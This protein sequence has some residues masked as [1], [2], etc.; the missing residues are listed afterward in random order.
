[1]KVGVVLPVYNQD[2]VY[3]K[4]AILSMESQTYRNFTF[5]IVIDGANQETIDA[6]Y[7]A[8]TQLTCDYSI[9]NRKENM[10][11]AHSLNEGFSHLTDCTHLTWVSSDNR[12][13]P[14]FLATLVAQYELAPINT[15]LVYSLYYAINEKGERYI[16]E[17]EWITI[18]SKQM[19]RKKEIIMSVCF[20]GVSF[21][22][23]RSAFEQAGGYKVEYGKVAD[24][25]L[26]MR[27][28]NF[29]EFLFLPVP[30]I[31]YRHN[32]AYSLTTQT[33]PEEL[34]QDSM[35]ASI[36]NRIMDGDIP[37]V[38]VLITAHNHEKYIKQCLDSV[39]NQT[40]KSFH[41]VVAVDASTD[42]TL[43]IVVNNFDDS[44]IIPI[45]LNKQSK[46]H[47][48]NLGLEYSLGEYILEL[49]GDDWIDPNTLETMVNQMENLPKDVGMA[50]ANR[51]LWFEQPDGL[52]YGG[53]IYPGI[54]YKDKYEVLSLMQTHCPRLY[55]KSALRQIGGWQTEIEGEPLHAD[56]YM[57]F[58]KMSEQFKL[59]W[60]D[61]PF[62]HQRRHSNN[63]T[64]YKKDILNRQFK[65]VA[66]E[67]MNRWGDTARLEFEEADGSVT[68]IN[69]IRNIVDG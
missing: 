47:A 63:I 51:K 42:S 50:Y 33:P 15:V 37:K 60:I 13:L 21:L 11:F 57:I 32:G 1:M 14:T 34:F 24:H 44:R 9:I 54:V 27:L 19:Y 64:T 38:T 10:G 28:K 29:G 22:F 58:I 39:L 53:P 25:E 49:D 5:V 3:V 40:F 17:K 56:D 26:W 20:I 48:L 43:G 62:Y 4:E 6:V 61:E 2:P 52:M 66:Q 7:E 36:D 8:S 16:P 41:V 12:Q 67:A 30:L 31:E 23:T 18:M 65:K 45:M 55:R 68:K 59:H 35:K 46:A 69:I